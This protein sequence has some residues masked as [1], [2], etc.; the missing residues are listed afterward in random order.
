MKPVFIGT[1][2]ELPSG[3]YSL[4]FA[5]PR[6]RRQLEQTLGQVR[7]HDVG[8]RVYRVGLPPGMGPFGGDDF[9]QVENDEQRDNR[10]A[11]ERGKP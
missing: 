2:A 9:L 5:N 7:A 11:S 3:G 4:R 6:T 1:I 8:K 10:L